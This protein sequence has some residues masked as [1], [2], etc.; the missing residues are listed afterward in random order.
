MMKS[1]RTLA[2]KETRAQKITSILIL[3]AIILSS[4][5]TA[6]IGQSAGVLSAMRQQQAITLGG[7]RYVTFLQMNQEQVAALQNDPRLSFVGNYVTLGTTA[8]NPSLSLGLNEYQEDVVA[9]YPTV[10][11]LKEGRLPEAPMEIALPEDVLQHL[12]LVGN[13]GELVSLPLSKPLRHGIEISSYDFMADFLLVGILESNYLNY[14]FGGV[15]GVVGKGTAASLLPKNY[16][17][18]NV[19]IRMV[20]KSTFQETVNDLISTL[21]VHELDTLYNVPYLDALGIRYDSG[22]SD[23]SGRGF[24][25]MLAAGIMVG[26]LLLAAA[27]LVI[28][29]IMKIAVSQRIRQYGTLRAIGGEKRQLYFLVTAQVLLLC[30]IGIPIGLLLG[31][32]SAKGILTAA[33]SFVSPEIFLVQNRDELN[34]LIS[35][36]RSGKGIFLLVSAFIT[37]FFAL[38]AAIPAARY[39]AKVSPT[40]AMAGRNIKIKR[41]NRKTKKIRN[42]EALYAWLNLKRNRG[43][44][45]ITILS[46]VMSITVFIALQSF[47]SLLD[48]SSAMPDHLGDYSVVNEY[49][50]IS[51][52][53]LAALE[54]DKNVFA[55]AAEQF[56]LYDLDEQYLPIG[57]ETSITLGIGECLQIVGLNDCWIE[58]AFAQRLALEQMEQLKAGEGCV[59]RNPIP[60]QV[61]EEQIG[62]TQ[63]EA[64]TNIA[65]A[66]KEFP[67]LLSL[68]GYDTYFSVGNNG[69]TNGI[70]VLVSDRLYPQ[71]TGIE[72]YAELR[73]ILSSDADRS[74]FDK[75]LES[76]SQRIPG[77]TVL[78]YEQA[79][80]QKAES[81]EQIRLLAWGLILFVAIIGLLNIINTVYTNIHTRI[82]E[83]GTHRAIGMSAEGLYSV[84]LWEGAYYGLFAALIGSIAGYICTIFVEAAKTDTIQLA[85]VP[86]IPIAEAT[87]LA[88]CACLLATC[89]PLWKITKLSIVDSIEAVE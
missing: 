20:N 28:Y 10:S 89:I 63:I 45:A 51:S 21:G 6:V 26:L 32:L 61:G 66:G 74:A 73:P 39:A 4:M 7:N 85:A 75:V 30:V 77:S 38:I 17:Y 60:M 42:Y 80:R 11:R 49:G 71:L 29:N 57:I 48:A 88:I 19:D 47:S 8:L 68:N 2:L 64:G 33:T 35:E 24:S 72:T 5:M 12:G 81:F 27:G 58:D 56:S 53:E 86:I 50:G 46:L 65:V 84:F 52:G 22:W 16:L 37:L 79:D 15:T 83:I 54:A 67:V 14:T 13:L 43:R 1:Y 34:L 31:T 59:I 69:F 40:V 25:L 82:A 36:S 3:V 9:I 55:V 76:L 87:F 78:S 18:Y 41:R 44:T 70:Q 23:T 62:T